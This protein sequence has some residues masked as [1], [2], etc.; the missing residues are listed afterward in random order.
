MGKK[1]LYI[2]IPVMYNVNM[3]TYI[4]TSCSAAEDTRV[5][6]HWSSYI[7][8]L[9]SL[10]L[11]VRGRVEDIAVIIIVVISVHV[12]VVVVDWVRAS[13]AKARRRRQTVTNLEKSDVTIKIC[14]GSRREVLTCSRYTARV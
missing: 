13:G 9:L 2:P 1:K 10:L 5:Q 14:T 12:V 11:C 7:I 8:I 4:G 6:Y 3:P